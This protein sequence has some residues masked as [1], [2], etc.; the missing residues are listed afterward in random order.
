MS[1]VQ[2]EI[3]FPPDAPPASMTLADIQSANARLKAQKARDEYRRALADTVPLAEAAAAAQACRDLLLDALRQLRRDQLQAIAG[4]VDETRIHYLMADAAHAWAMSLGAAIKPASSACP[5]IGEGIRRGCRPRDLIAVSQWADRHRW[6]NIGTNAPGQW[7]TALTPYLREIMDSLSEHSPVAEVVFV[8]SV[9]VGATEA[10]S[11]WIGY[12]MHHLGNRDMLV[13]VPTKDF[14][15]QTF[16]PRFLRLLTDT[17]AL[18]DLVSLGGRDRRNTEGL[19]EYGAGAK[20]LK[21]GANTANDLSS[22]SLPY[23]ACD[24]VDKFP[25]SIP[26]VGDPMRL[27]EGRQTTFTR[28]KTFLLSTPTTLEKSRIWREWLASDQRRYQVPCPHC[29]D[30]QALEFGGP[31]TPYG[32]KWIKAPASDDRSPPRVARVWYVCR[33]C[34]AVIEEGHKTDMLARGR[35]VADRPQIAHRRGYHINALYAPVG[36]GRDWAWLANRWLASLGSSD[37][38]QVFYNEQ[39]GLPWAEDYE[40]ADPD[41]I[42]ARLE[43]YGQERQPGRVRSVGI[44]VQKDV[45][46]VSVYD[47]GV[48][49]ETWGIDHHI[50]PG[51]TLTPEPWEALA[52]L[53]AA[54]RPD[55][56]GLDTGYNAER[57]YDFCRPR[58][59]LFPLKGVRN[60]GTDTLIEDDGKRR[61]RLRHRRK[62]GVAPFLVSNLIGMREITERLN[63]PPPE[64]GQP[65][66]RYLHFPAGNPAFDAGFFQQLTSN[67]R[68]TRKVRHKVVIEWQEQTPN[69]AYDCWK[70]ALAGFRLSRLDPAR[71]RLPPA[72]TTPADDSVRAPAFADSGIDITGWK[73]GR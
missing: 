61:Q 46:E 66:G 59:W 42:L 73:R 30:Y 8:K 9:Q 41:A 10:M 2:A 60:L 25:E 53:L 45:I 7:R 4:E 21:V 12:V 63:L 68:V 58:P 44:D 48:D 37:E 16:N 72:S 34:A 67:R 15:D 56:G 17:P 27:I 1:A 51:A 52:D 22:H 24:E 33:H 13:V 35:W 5:A 14:R 47:I 20:I 11:N 50:V 71:H 28:R 54:L 62:T 18:A 69:E 38:M 19:L 64:S 65:R 36:L 70:Y 29:G 57:A 49:E 26:G 31:E 23:V 39:L 32:L 40:K 43:P 3:D 55:C 6:L